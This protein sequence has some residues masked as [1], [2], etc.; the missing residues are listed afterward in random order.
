MPLLP[1]IIS[2]KVSKSSAQMLYLMLARR[3]TTEAELRLLRSYNKKEAKDRSIAVKT[4][5]TIR[6]D[7]QAFVEKTVKP[8]A[9]LDT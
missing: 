2:A 4:D 1:L 7:V 5:V 8:S 9:R 6:Q 3:L